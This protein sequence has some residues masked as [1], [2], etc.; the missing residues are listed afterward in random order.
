MRNHRAG[1]P[2]MLQAVR[3]LLDMHATLLAEKALHAYDTMIAG[4]A[5]SPPSAVKLDHLILQGRL[6]LQLGEFAKAEEVLMEAVYK[7]RP[8]TSRL[9][10]NAPEPKP[11]PRSI[12]SVEMW[13]YLAHAQCMQKKPDAIHS[14]TTVLEM[15]E[16]PLDNMVYL[17]LGRMLTD[18]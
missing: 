5:R 17:R 3:F 7:E 15:R 14:Y 16:H 12:F 11:Q 1:G 6:Y 2:P 9:S 4:S 8:R 18:A 13:T 10:A